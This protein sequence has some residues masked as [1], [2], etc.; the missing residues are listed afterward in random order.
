MTFETL[1]TRLPFMSAIL[2]F[3]ACCKTIYLIYFLK[4]S[5]VT[6]GKV[7]EIQSDNEGDTPFVEFQTQEGKKVKFRVTTLLGKEN[8][9]L[10]T[11]WPVRYVPSMPERAQIDTPHYR[12]IPVSVLLFGSI[13]LFIVA[14]GLVLVF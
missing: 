8:W 7:V 1:A 2:L 13:F 12:W 9:S 4:K 14:K 6:I 5:R 11:I 10:D 3:L